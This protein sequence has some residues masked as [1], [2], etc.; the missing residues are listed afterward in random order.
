MPGKSLV[1]AA[2]YVSDEYE[3]AGMKDEYYSL[4]LKCLI[5]D[6]NIAK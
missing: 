2:V 3:C 5:S 4:K 6:C 1:W